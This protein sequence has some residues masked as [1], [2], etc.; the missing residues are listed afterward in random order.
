ML[1][2]IVENLNEALQY[3][4]FIA[5]FYLTRKREQNDSKSGS[6]EER[7]GNG[8]SITT[9]TGFFRKFS[10]SQI[11]SDIAEL[12][13]KCE[14]IERNNLKEHERLVEALE[15]T[16]KTLI[17][18]NIGLVQLRTQFEEREKKR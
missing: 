8:R 17:E 2:K 1:D 5:V 6:S 13:G 18:L 15:I 12:K 14:V 4:I 3:I 10:I 9:E 16:N 11:T 7:S